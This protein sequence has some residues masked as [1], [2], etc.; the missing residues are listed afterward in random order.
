MSTLLS[1]GKQPLSLLADFSLMNL[2]PTLAR[3]IC[4]VPDSIL[5]STTLTDSSIQLCDTP[6]LYAK[7]PAQTA[8]PAVSSFFKQLSH[9]DQKTIQLF[10]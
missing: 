7:I 2:V 6:Q 9:H 1:M 5:F 10:A 3:H 4:A 8:N